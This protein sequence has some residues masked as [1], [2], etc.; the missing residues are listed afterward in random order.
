MTYLAYMLIP[1]Y[2]ILA[3]VCLITFTYERVAQNEQER[4]GNTFI[5]NEWS[6]VLGRYQH[7]QR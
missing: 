3:I 7:Q 6:R 4:V 1:I 5:A 2:P